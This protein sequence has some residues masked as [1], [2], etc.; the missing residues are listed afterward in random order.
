MK[1]ILSLVILFILILST[2]SCSKNRELNTTIS[3]EELTEIKYM[4]RIGGD[5]HIYDNLEDL[6]NRA[7]I[8]IHCRL[9]NIREPVLLDGHKPEVFENADNL[10]FDKYGGPIT[11]INTPY[12]FEIINIYYGNMK[13]EKIFTLYLPYGNINGFVLESDFPIFEIDEEYVLFM[14]KRNIIIET[15]ER[16]ES[17]TLVSPIQGWISLSYDITQKREQ[18]RR[19]VLNDE[20][21]KYI[22][23]VEDSLARN[24]PIVT[25]DILYKDY[26]SIEDIMNKIKHYSARR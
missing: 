11:S 7:E 9:V 24:T 16:I 25:F 3:D 6:V 13:E 8:T 23:S 12:E 22:D 21:E 4:A 1:K 17:Y 19:F 15:G 2:Y 5:Q 20:I 14:T 26:N 18:Y 10:E